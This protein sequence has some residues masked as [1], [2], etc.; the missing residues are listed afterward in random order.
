MSRQKFGGSWT[1]EKLERV[2]KYLERYTTALK[3][4]RF[5]LLYI[6]A[7]AGTGYRT[8]QDIKAEGQLP[9]DLPEVG[10]L[11]KG[12]A[13]R[14]LE[15]T[16]AFDRYVFIE[17]NKKNFDQLVRLKIE[18]ADKLDRMTFI[19]KEA[20]T[21]ITS[22]CE[23]VKWQSNR[24]VM[25]LDPY[26]MQVNWTTIE[27]IAATKAIDLWYLFPAGMGVNRL[28]PHD[29]QIPSE[30]RA[31]LDR[32]LGETSWRDEFYVQSET[33]DLFG[34][35]TAKRRKQSDIARIE[36]YF[37]GRLRTIFAGV[38]EHGLPLRNSKQQCMYLLTFACGNPRGA[39]I[40]LR[41][42]EAI[43]KD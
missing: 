22:L 12:S 33:T 35:V 37:L 43:L 13:R 17:R 23:A 19:N 18:F 24:A 2:A 5:Q 29:A 27:K 38:A 9:L 6:D 3:N 11:A 31:A 7:F 41:I 26:G 10:M 36:A 30:W 40:A 34:T 1:E 25:F 4:Q 8:V 32:M 16:P 39:T 20:N 14:A 28:T 15:V 42:A 21:A